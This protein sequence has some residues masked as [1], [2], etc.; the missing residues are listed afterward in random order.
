MNIWDSA[1]GSFAAAL[2]G[3][4]DPERQRQASEAARELSIAGNI[5][6][7]LT[8][9]LKGNA[10]AD[11]AIA[12]LSWPSAIAFSHSG[13]LVAAGDCDGYVRV[14]EF[15]SRTVVAEFHAGED[16]T[17]DK[18]ENVRRLSFSPTD[19]T[20]TVE[21]L[22]RMVNTPEWPEGFLGGDSKNPKDPILKSASTGEVIARL[23]LFKGR[24]V[25]TSLEPFVMSPD[26]RLMATRVADNSRSWKP[27]D[28]NKNSELRV[29][30][31]QDGALKY[32]I[33]QE[34]PIGFPPDGRT[35]L[36]W[37]RRGELQLWDLER[38]RPLWTL[39][40]YPRA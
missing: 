12:L 38:M 39:R 8:R 40:D 18:C 4:K 29:W 36:T 28:F 32:T 37:T 11:C 35:I 21:V 25:A 23:V 13:H 16:V 6:K 17:P 19:K 9:A 24:G 1:T 2:S 27:R 10:A 15:A 20:L 30:D 26:G 31:A 22:T 14:W 5:D 33:K 34:S 3:H 7:L